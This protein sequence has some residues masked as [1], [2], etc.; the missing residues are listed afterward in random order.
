MPT[1]T[2]DIDHA[3]T[4]RN[5]MIFEDDF[6]KDCKKIIQNTARNTER[7]A[8][9]ETSVPRSVA[10]AAKKRRVKPRRVSN[11]DPD[12][13]MTVRSRAKYAPHAHLFTGGTVERT[14]IARGRTGRI[15]PPRPFVNAAG[16]YYAPK[17]ER[18]IQ[19]RIDRRVNL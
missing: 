14:R 5:A 6:R 12:F 16:E 1:V 10:A 2:V 7:R 13:H 4:I 9:G 18:Q 15:N 17:F 11:P 8:R 19:E 3:E